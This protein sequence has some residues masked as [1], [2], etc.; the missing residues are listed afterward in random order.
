MQATKDCSQRSDYFKM[1]LPYH[2]VKNQR[3]TAGERVRVFTSHDLNTYHSVL[4]T[5]K[6]VR[7]ILHVQMDLFEKDT[8]NI[9]NFG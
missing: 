4:I 3:S 5:V 2:V 9:F 8:S 1:K 6:H 7:Y